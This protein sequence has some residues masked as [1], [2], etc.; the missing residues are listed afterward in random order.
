V[1]G[2]EPIHG[3]VARLREPAADLG[4]RLAQTQADLEAIDAAGLGVAPGCY[5]DI[6]RQL[7]SLPAPIE[8]ARLF[9]VD[10][11]KPVIEA[12]LGRAVLDEI[13]RGIEILHRLA[14]KPAKDRDILA[15]FRDAFRGRYEGREVP[16]VE[17]LD[18]EHGIGFDTLDGKGLNA[19]T[20]LDG[21]TFP[22][23]AE[24]TVP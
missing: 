23:P 5:R 9:Q 19:S 7:A 10:M 8:L 22:P 18:E 16:L 24:E 11:I 17:A 12:T 13:G 6:A 3:L 1:T 2:P 15:R 20:L 4:Q 14:R 21:L